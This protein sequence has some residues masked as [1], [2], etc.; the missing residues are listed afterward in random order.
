MEHINTVDN[1]L[2]LLVELVTKYLEN[3]L[4]SD[5]EDGTIVAD[6]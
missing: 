5:N 2:D 1:I 3:Q 4:N 6:V